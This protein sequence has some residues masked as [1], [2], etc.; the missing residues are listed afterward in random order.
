MLKFIKEA[1]EA[2]VAKN[3]NPL[4]IEKSGK[5]LEN[6][7]RK[8]EKTISNLETK[9]DTLKVNIQE[10]EE[11]LEALSK[12]ETVTYMEKLTKNLVSEFN[13]CHE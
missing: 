6:L 2:V 1:T 13:L 12:Q 8:S 11:S 7:N 9:N 4:K 3:E 5:E 10:K